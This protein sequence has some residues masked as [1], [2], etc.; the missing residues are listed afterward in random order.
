MSAV[1]VFLSYSD[2]YRC[3]NQPLENIRPLECGRIELVTVLEAIL[4][5]R[6]AREKLQCLYEILMSNNFRKTAVLKKIYICL[7]FFPGIFCRQEENFLQTN[8]KTI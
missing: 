2:A 6:Q 3:T 8:V 7:Q 1:S 5:R 4:A